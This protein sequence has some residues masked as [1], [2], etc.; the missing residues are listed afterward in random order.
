MTANGFDVAKV[1]IVYIGTDDMYI[2]NWNEFSAAAAKFSDINGKSLN[3]QYT[4][5]KDGSSWE[6]DTAGWYAVYIRYINGGKTCN[7]YYTAEIK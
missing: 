2:S 5:P 3:W 4:N 1:T 7:S 6:Q